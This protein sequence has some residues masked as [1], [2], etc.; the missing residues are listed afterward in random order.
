MAHTYRQI[1]IRT[2]VTALVAYLSALLLAF[3][4][5]TTISIE[6]AFTMLAAQLIHDTSLRYCIFHASNF[7]QITF[8]QFFMPLAVSLLVGGYLNFERHVFSDSALYLNLSS[9][10]IA[11]FAGAFFLLMQIVL[12][13]CGEA[14]ERIIKLSK[15][16]KTHK[17][18]RHI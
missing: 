9:L 15:H 3:S 6:L 13:I 2:L 14:L 11:C 4:T 1:V 5:N 8:H 17:G 7:K 10:Q 16:N 12:A 18:T